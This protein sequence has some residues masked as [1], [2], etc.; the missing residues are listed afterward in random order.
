MTDNG[1]QIVRVLADKCFDVT[2]SQPD[3]E[4][5]LHSTYLPALLILL[6]L[7]E[8]MQDTWALE[9][10]NSLYEGYFETDRSFFDKVLKGLYEGGM[11]S[12]TVINLWL[13]EIPH[14]PIKLDWL[15]KE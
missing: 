13:T 15:E 4:K 5:E 6:S 2:H 1:R 3:W 8:K 9:I 12:R 11:I 7:L 10:I 14:S